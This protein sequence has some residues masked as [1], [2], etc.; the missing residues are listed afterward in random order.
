MGC[1][2]RPARVEVPEFDPDKIGARAIELF[3]KDGDGSLS[4]AERG[5]VK[6]LES[7]VQRLDKDGDGKLTAAEIAARIEFYHEFRAGLLPVYCTL[8]SGGRPVAGA[9]LTYEPDEFMGANALP[10]YGTTNSQGSTE[11]SMAEEHRPSP[12]F[13]GVQ[14]GFYRIRVTLADGTDVTSL[15]AGIECAGDV[16]NNHTFAIPAR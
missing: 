9:R 10:A 6:S 15:D 3:D 11:V 5:S 8:V 16:M 12:A 13:T 2:S 4:S 7:A 1:T 14:P